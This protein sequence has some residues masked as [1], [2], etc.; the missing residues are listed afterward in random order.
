MSHQAMEIYR[1]R[2][3]LCWGGFEAFG[4]EPPT[5]VFRFKDPEPDPV[6]EIFVF[7]TAGEEDD[8][9]GRPRLLV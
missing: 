8:D 1:L 5:L 6:E 3:L 7:A 4:D 9:I 2:L